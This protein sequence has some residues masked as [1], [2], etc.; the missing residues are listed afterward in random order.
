M[1]EFVYLEVK[2]KDIV[3]ILKGKSDL[4]QR[5]LINIIKNVKEKSDFNSIYFEGILNEL[6]MSLEN[7]EY[8]IDTFL[9]YDNDLIYY[10][11]INGNANSFNKYSKLFDLEILFENH[12]KH[13]KRIFQTDSM[14]EIINKGLVVDKTFLD[15]YTKAYKELSVNN[16]MNFI[17]YELFYK[18]LKKELNNFYN[19]KIIELFKSIY[20][21]ANFKE[22]YDTMLQLIRDTYF[23]R[24]N[25]KVDLF[26]EKLLKGDYNV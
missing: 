12:V 9:E 22:S 1:L 24:T 3:D 18:E 11:L 25:N 23:E 7:R 16:D 4:E 13:M 6:D 17:S 2:E 21:G 26:F 8:F 14:K 15:C 19:D 20:L 10:S 5:K